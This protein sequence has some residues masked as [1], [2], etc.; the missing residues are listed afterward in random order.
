VKKR[1]TPSKFVRSAVAVALCYVVVLQAFL[2]SCSLALAVSRVSPS[3]SAVICHGDGGNAPAGPDDRAPTSDACAACAICTLASADGLPAPTTPAVA[4]PR[5]AS[6]RVAPFA[7][8]GLPGAPPA[9]A[10]FARAPP[11]FA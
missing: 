8:A 1:Q 9:R 10:G 7:I 3:A 4:A 6:H 11:K 2:A 5:T